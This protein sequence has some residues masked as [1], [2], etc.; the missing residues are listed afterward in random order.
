MASVFKR[1]RKVTRP[2]GRKI[3]RQSSCWYVK[4][5]DADGIEQ[6][7]KGFKDKEAT[8][9][10]AAKLEREAE[11]GRVGVVDRYKEHRIRPLREHLEDFRRSLLA[12]GNTVKHVELTL[13]RVR[14]VVEGCRF[15]VWG[16]ISASRVELFLAGLQE[17]EEAL[18]AQTANYYL[19][20][21]KQFCGW[22]VNDGRA[23]E[24]PLAHLQKKRTEKARQ[25]AL[26]PDELRR[27]LEVTANGPDCYGMTGFARAMLYRLAAESGLRSNELR[28]LR[29]SSL[30]LGKR[31]VRIASG[32]A[33]NRRESVLPLRADT[34][35]R[36]QELLCNRVPTA[37]AFDLPSKYN[38]AKMLRADLMRAGIE[39]SDE[40]S[41]DKYVNFHSLRH[42]TG[43]LLAASGAHPKV[44]QAIMRHSDINLTMSR[45]THTLR[46]QE[47]KAIE[48]LPDPALPSTQAQQG[49]KTGTDDDSAG[50]ELE[51]FKELTPQLTPDLTPT[52]FSGCNRLATE[53][54]TTRVEVRR[55]ANRKPPSE[56][57]LST[58]T[59][60]M[61]PHV[62]SKRGTRP[63]GLEPPTYGLEIRCSIQLSYGRKIS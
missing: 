59:T 54:K 35:A 15:A 18:A 21:M 26:E 24:S 41:S 25:R 9:Q 30:D 5:R 55:S 23:A 6:R 8:R 12:K 13:S 36:L 46:G 11:L 10:L 50:Q 17:G 34:A 3:V 49:V 7:V 20:S 29:V 39:Y 22:M 4:Y 62:I 56:E 44:A 31:T 14:A 28:S 16:D 32:S 61:S 60:A 53:G 51:Q 43:T 19:A 1:K 33:K 48:S 45:Y 58:D 27:V 47:A 2:D 52:A 63:G 37:R 38:M 57:D 42:T 40:P